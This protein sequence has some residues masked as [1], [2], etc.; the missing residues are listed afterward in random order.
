MGNMGENHD[1]DDD[2]EKWE[3]RLYDDNNNQVTGSSE[4]DAY[5]IMIKT[6]KT[7]VAT[8]NDQLCFEIAEMYNERL[9][10]QGLVSDIVPVN[11]DGCG[12]GDNNGSNSEWEQL[13]MLY[14]ISFIN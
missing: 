12:G 8:I 1:D 5:Q 10:K 13:N 2:D 14:Y 4:S 7:G 9:R 3:L 6:H 11:S